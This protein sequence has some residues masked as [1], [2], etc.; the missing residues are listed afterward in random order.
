MGTNR[1][2]T[3]VLKARKVVQKGRGAVQW[4]RGAVQRCRGAV[5]WCRGGVLRCRGAVQWCRGGVLRYRGAVSGVGAVFW[6]VMV[7]LSGPVPLLRELTAILL[8]GV[9]A[10]F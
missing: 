2:S 8:R 7:E 6:G 1:S 9:D 10:T 3:C 5:Q 4:C